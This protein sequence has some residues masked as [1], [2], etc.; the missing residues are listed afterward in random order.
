MAWSRR[1]HVTS[2]IH[3]YQKPLITM[4]DHLHFKG[5]YAYQ[6]TDKMTYT[7]LLQITKFSLSEFT[8]QSL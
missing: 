4:N 2:G 7:M 8:T 3:R 1:V 6:A 5:L